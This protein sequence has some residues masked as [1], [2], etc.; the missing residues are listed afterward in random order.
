MLLGLTYQLDAA[1][2]WA[3]KV[4]RAIYLLRFVRLQ[5]RDSLTSTSPN[6]AR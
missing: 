3:S 1:L 4:T 5:P 6:I 2:A